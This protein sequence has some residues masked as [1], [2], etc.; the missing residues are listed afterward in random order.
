MI[1]WLVE[2]T[3]LITSILCLLIVSGSW[4]TKKIGPSNHYLLW[5]VVPLS[6]CIS[7]IDFSLGLHKSPVPAFVVSAKTQASELA[8]HASSFSET[9]SILW[10]LGFVAILGYV[11]VLHSR[12]VS[13]VSKKSRKSGDEVTP[14]NLNSD[15]GL[16][17][18]KI[19]LRFAQ[20]NSSPYVEGL[21]FPTLVLPSNFTTLFDQEQQSLILKHELVHLKRRD[22]LWNMLALTLLS[23]FWFNPIFWRAYR[24]FRLLQELSCDQ[25]ALQGESKQT[26][27]RYAKA[28]LNSSSPLPIF[29]LNQLSFG[30]KAMLKERLVQLKSNNA[31]SFVGRSA[32]VV[33]ILLLGAMLTLANAK[34]SHTSSD[35]K[36]IMRVNPQY[37]IEAAEKGI[38]GAVIMS[39]DV[40]PQGSVSNVKVIGSVPEKVFDHNA[41][42][43]LSQWEYDNPTGNT[44]SA[45]VQ[46][47]FVL[48]SDSR[49]KIKVVAQ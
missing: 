32:A 39:F 49:E 34:V 44:I 17:E 21:L 19:K 42:L 36:P 24:R 1:N 23:V 7:T 9:L 18:S 12:G 33:S 27:L 35:L 30:E 43:A 31:S 8:S 13:L 11:F 16:T 48:S 37:P 45:E 40:D 46:I 10:M 38:E 14:F 25:I 3:L 4:L 6:L 22:I 28:L 15:F 41:K 5:L 29:T 26:R 2:Q 47:D 20:E